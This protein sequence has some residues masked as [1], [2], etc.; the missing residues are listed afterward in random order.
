MNVADYQVVFS[1]RACGKGAQFGISN[2]VGR[3]VAVL[4]AQDD[5]AVGAMY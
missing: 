1:A 4:W 2:L 3:S 5:G